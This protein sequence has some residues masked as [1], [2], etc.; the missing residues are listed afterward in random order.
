MFAIDAG[1]RRQRQ[2]QA[3]VAVVHRKLRLPGR[4]QRDEKEQR[5]R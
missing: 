1:D 5:R 2:H 3:L 4:Q